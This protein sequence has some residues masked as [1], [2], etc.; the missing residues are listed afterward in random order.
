MPKFKMRNKS[1]KITFLTIVASLLF[2]G[3]LFAQPQIAKD[4]FDGNSTISTWL[5]DDCIM[6]NNFINPYSTGI[7]TSSK[8]LKYSDV[9]GQYA[10]VR[11]DAGFNFNL[12]LGSKFSLKLYVPS[13]G[14]TGNQNNQI[15][16]KL[17]NG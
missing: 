3:T 2:C 13:S 17:Q 10:N 6:D 1:Y 16:L 12:S 4:N 5:G 14:I 11:F 15:S 7:N 8:V 9:G